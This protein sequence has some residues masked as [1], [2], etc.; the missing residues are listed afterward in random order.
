[1]TPDDAVVQLAGVINAAPEASVDQIYDSLVQNGLTEEAADRTYKFTQLAWGQAFLREVGV[2]FPEEYF[3]FDADGRVVERG[4]LP[5]E[6][7]FAAASRLA[8]QYR[9]TA[10][11]K[12][13]ALT[14]ADLQA[15]NE[16]LKAG[17]RPEDL[18]M[19]P[20]CIFFAEPTAEGMRKAESVID[21][22]WAALKQTS[23]EEAMVAILALSA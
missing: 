15:A 5:D 17:S 16:L 3:C 21:E 4:R 13:L 19:A 7:V 18:E 11:F 23:E 2:R 9:Y 10:A 6:V 1:M 20:P 22:H 14:S 12:R 8:A